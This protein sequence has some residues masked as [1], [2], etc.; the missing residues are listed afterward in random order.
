MKMKILKFFKNPQLLFFGV[1]LL[2]LQ[3]C[4]R[5]EC[6]PP[7]DKTG[8]VTLEIPIINPMGPCNFT[9]DLIPKLKSLGMNALVQEKNEDPTKWVI[10]LVIGGTCSDDAAWETVFKKANINVKTT[11]LNFGQTLDALSIT[12]N[13]LPKSFSGKT[14]VKVR[15]LSPC[16][17]ATC[18]FGQGL[19]SVTNYRVLFGA[20]AVELQSAKNGDTFTTNHVLSDGNLE[21]C[22]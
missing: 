19:P 8:N 1:V 4:G 3:S 14:T 5:S 18:S 16:R 7:D 17:N 10:E 22:N 13:D 15:L 9:N 11:T 21:S 2:L 6:G 20:V 12:M